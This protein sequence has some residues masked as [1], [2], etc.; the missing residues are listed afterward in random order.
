MYLNNL[1]FL[2]ELKADRKLSFIYLYLY[3]VSKQAK[4][5]LKLK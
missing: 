1:L 4:Q 2:S 5:S 3:I